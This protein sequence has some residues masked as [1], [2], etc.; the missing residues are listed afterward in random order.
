MS[1]ES[2]PGAVGAAEPAATAAITATPAT[3]T[4]GIVGMGY[5][6]LPTAVSLTEA[7][8][9]VIGLDSNADRL[10]RVA[11]G[12]VDLP[13]QDRARLLL[14]MRT[15]RLRLTGE[16]DALVEADVILVCVP[17]PVDKNLEPDPRILRSACDAVVARA[18]PG[19]TF[20]LTSTTYVGS[21]R[22][23]LV[24]PLARR[25][26]IAGEDVFVVF[27]PERINPGA[28]EHTQSTTPRVVGGATDLCANRASGVL[29]HSCEQIH[30][31]RSLEAAEMTKLYENTF[32]A[33]NIAL[34]FEMADACHHYGLDPI[35]VTDA[36]AT[37]PYAFM[38]HY[39]SA[40]V[41][42]HCIGV[43]PYYLLRPLRAAGT[44]AKMTER[45][46]EIV[47][48]RPERV[49]RRAKE[50]V[51]R[52]HGATAG[53][54]VLIVG[55]AYKPGVADVR[56]APAI[57]V[58]AALADSG[59]HVEYFDPLVP[60]LELGGRAYE[61]TP[62]P[63]PA[64]Y[65]LVVVATIHPDTDYGWLPASPHLLDCTHRAPGGRLRFVVSDA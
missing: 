42:G 24:E 50:L 9:A 64:S 31:V 63:D 57:H 59:T 19:Q 39:P 17:T 2:F 33:V 3:P 60:R 6:G 41:G 36:A 7:G 35:E 27:S 51:E 12:Q 28:V 38:A 21:T 49:A 56:E 29:R 22:E 20:V 15:G 37:K 47:S 8:I 55:V 32:R 65:D 18:R 45:A 44:P 1:V 5:V 53:A 43:D 23:M 25:G 11:S 46:L 30:R 34:A 52:V 16:A 54:R 10:R 26:L 48:A 40:G 13:A 14:E 61:H 62:A 4:V 58:L